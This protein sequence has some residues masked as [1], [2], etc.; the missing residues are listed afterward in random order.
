MNYNQIL[1]LLERDDVTEAEWQE[2]AAYI[3]EAQ[4][5]HWEDYL[6][7]RQ[8]FDDAIFTQIHAELGQIVRNRGISTEWVLTREGEIVPA[9]IVDGRY[10]QVW[11]VKKDWGYDAELVEWVNVSTASTIEKEQVHYAKKGYQIAL[12]EFK[13]RYGHKSNRTYLDRSTATLVKGE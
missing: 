8:N 1:E 5:K 2:A 12:A 9:V 11:A 10:G 6:E 3:D 7:R 4:T 13:V